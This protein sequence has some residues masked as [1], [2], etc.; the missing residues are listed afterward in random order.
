MNVIISIYFLFIDYI[1]LFDKARLVH[2]IS[3]SS[4]SM[5]TIFTF[6]VYIVSATH[7]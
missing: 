6:T 2:N 3:Q 5:K 7:Q 4:A 1:F